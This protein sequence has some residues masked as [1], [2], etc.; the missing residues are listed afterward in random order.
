MQ[1]NTVIKALKLRFACG[2]SGYKELL[3]RGH[4]LPSLRTLN[5]KIKDLKFDSGLC[6]EMFEFLRIKVETFKNETDKDCLLVL[7]EISVTPSD[8]DNTRFFYK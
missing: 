7:D 4:P 5:R 3:K 8:N 2:S 1:N 6:E